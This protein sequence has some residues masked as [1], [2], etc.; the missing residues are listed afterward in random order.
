MFV[1]INHDLPQVLAGIKLVFTSVPVVGCSTHGEISPE[2]ARDGSVLVMAIGGP[3]FAVTTAVAKNVSGRQRDAGAELA[4]AV[5]RDTGLPYTA[6]LILTDGFIRDQED[7]LRGIYSVVGASIPLVGGAAGDGWRFQGTEQI[8]GDEV[9]SDAVVVASISSEAPIAVGVRHGWRKVGEPMVVTGC[10]DGRVHT[11]DDQPAMDVYLDRVGAPPEAYTDAN[12]FS[13]F[14][15]SRP[16]GFMRRSGEVVRNLS[17]EVDLAGRSLGGG[18]QIPLGTVAWLME[19]DEPSILDAATEAC[20][21]AID[22]LQGAPLLGMLTSTA[23]RYAP[24]SAM[25]E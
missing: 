15:L 24:L 25:S 2:G 9:L 17:T 6:M 14:A 8:H 11:L 13:Q 4:D 19:G 18:G 21:D 3:G 20:R 7:I 5:A 10:G 12:A 16:L 22:A 23:P 1:G